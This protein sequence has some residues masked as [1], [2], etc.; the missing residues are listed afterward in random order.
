MS[1]VCLIERK[2][3]A[4]AADRKTKKVLVQGNSFAEVRAAV[5]SIYPTGWDIDEVL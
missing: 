1:L 2:P 4:A 3:N 5:R